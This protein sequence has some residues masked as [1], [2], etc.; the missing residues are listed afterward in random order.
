MIK[1]IG[2]EMRLRVFNKRLKYKCEARRIGLYMILGVFK[3][4]LKYK[5]EEIR[6][7]D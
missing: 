7:A 3:K 5:C 6:M 4:R 2:F 1:R